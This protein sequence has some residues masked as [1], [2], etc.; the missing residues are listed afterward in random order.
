[1][2]GNEGKEGIRKK[3]GQR[4]DVGGIIEGTYINHKGSINIATQSLR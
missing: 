3:R 4:V 1:M 2:E